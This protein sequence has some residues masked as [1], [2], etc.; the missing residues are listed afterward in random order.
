[1]IGNG[2]NVFVT[3]D[4]TALS[5]GTPTANKKSSGKTDEKRKFIKRTVM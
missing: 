1:M 4:V 2:K 3:R 5:A